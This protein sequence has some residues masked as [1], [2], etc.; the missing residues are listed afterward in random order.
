MRAASIAVV[1]LLAAPAFAAPLAVSEPIVVN[2]PGQTA[3]NALSNL[4]NKIEGFF[5]RDF[6]N[7][8][9]QHSARD[10][11][12]IIKQA[13]TLPP[14]DKAKVKTALI[15]KMGTLNGKQNATRGLGGSI[16]SS[17]AGGAASGLVGN[18]LSEV[19]A[20]SY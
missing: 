18:I 14:A 9:S 13:Q 2:T 7:G 20:T 6:E 4:L 11:A 3:G 1:A 5:K 17:A 15:N 16:L 8:L 19:R 12:A 10:L